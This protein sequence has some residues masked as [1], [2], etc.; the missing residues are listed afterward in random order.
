MVMIPDDSKSCKINS[1]QISSVP[2][3]E[4]VRALGEAINTFKGGAILVSHDQQ[5]IKL[6]CKE[7]WLVKDKGVQS[8]K[9]GY[10]EYRRIVENELKDTF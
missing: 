3:I 6:C 10:D 7:L 2:D 1:H 5:L 4:S 8:I 9:G